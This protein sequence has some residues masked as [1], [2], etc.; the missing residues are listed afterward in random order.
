[1]GHHLQEVPVHLAEQD[2]AEDLGR[3]P[4]RRDPARVQHRDP[5]TAAVSLDENAILPSGSDGGTTG[6]GCGSGAGGS[7]GAVTSSTTGGTGGSLA[8]TG[9]DVPAAGPLAAA[10][11]LAAA[12][13]AGTVYAA[14][15]RRTRQ[16]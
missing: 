12:A 3:G 6:G 8:S 2:A 16:G 13:G 10:A 4:G 7:T 9:A 5:V 11:A 14:G 15:R 1:M